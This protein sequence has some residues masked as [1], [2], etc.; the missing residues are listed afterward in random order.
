MGTQTKS[1]LA[2]KEIIKKDDITENTAE[3]IIAELF[4]E[5]NLINVLLYAEEIANTYVNTDVEMLI[6]IEK[7]KKI[8]WNI[9]KLE[10]INRLGKEGLAE[11]HREHRKAWWTVTKKG[12][13]FIQNSQK[14]QTNNG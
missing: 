3:N 14:E 11:Y 8:L 4:S 7:N 10:Q 12:L 2:I 6:D 1:F 9:A 13:E 5:K